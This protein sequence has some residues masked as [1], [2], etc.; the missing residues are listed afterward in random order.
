MRTAIGVLGGF[1]VLLAPPSSAQQR[2]ASQFPVPT[3]PTDTTP[4]RCSE[5][6]ALTARAVMGYT[7]MAGGMLG[8][9]SI[10][11]VLCGENGSESCGDRIAVPAAMLVGAASAA[12]VA[13]AAQSA[14]QEP[15]WVPTLLGTSP[16]AA[17]IYG[18][19]A[20]DDEGALA[21]AF[22]GLS[23][24]PLG[25]VAGNYLGQP[26]RECG[27]SCGLTSRVV[28][29]VTGVVAGVLLATGLRYGACGSPTTSR[30][31][32]AMDAAGSALVGAMSAV[33]VSLA[34]RSTGARPAWVTTVAGGTIGALVVYGALRD[35]VDISA[36]GATFLLTPLLTVYGN[37]LGQ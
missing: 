15:A 1:L 27:E 21:L 26:P 12:G 24:I 8:A 35:D 4:R 22:A 6:C 2:P 7:G 36:F 23:V 28:L 10:H 33:G 14:G 34:A 13:L 32:R 37:H 3:P 29:G 9:V 30:C 17:L 20:T 11:Y 16:G 19:F 5:A 25:A 18:A 31:D